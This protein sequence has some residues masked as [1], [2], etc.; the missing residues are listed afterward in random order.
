MFSKDIDAVGRFVLDLG[1]FISTACLVCGTW[2]MRL[3][4]VRPFVPSGH[5]MPQLWVCCCVHGGQDICYMAC[6][7]KCGQC[8]VVSMR[9]KLD[10]DLQRLIAAA[11]FSRVFPGNCYNGCSLSLTTPLISCSPQGTQST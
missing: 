11:Q 10:T 1:Q 3:S 2:S 9:R 4:G 6:S 8:H 5:H 7:G